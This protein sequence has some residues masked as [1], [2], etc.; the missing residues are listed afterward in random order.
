MKKKKRKRNKCNIKRKRYIRRLVFH[1]KSPVHP[2]SESRGGGLSVMNKRKDDWKFLC[3]ILKFCYQPI[4][5][6]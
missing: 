1:Q 6:I 2:V 5:S 3:L 4:T